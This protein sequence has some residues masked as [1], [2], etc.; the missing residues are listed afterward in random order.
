MTSERDDD[1]LI[2]FTCDKCPETLETEHDEWDTAWPVAKE[3]GWR[4]FRLGKDWRHSCPDCV[5]KWRQS[6][7]Q[8]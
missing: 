4:A 6:Q 1:G 2:V 7:E 8:A 3:A 5:E